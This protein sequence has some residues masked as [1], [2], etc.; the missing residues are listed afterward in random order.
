MS[1]VKDSLNSLDS[2][3]GMFFK[4]RR[5]IEDDGHF[6]R[7]EDGTV[8]ARMVGKDSLVGMF[9]KGRRII[10]DDGHFIRVE[11]GT[12]YARMVGGGFC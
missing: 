4:G 8:Y 9:F 2:L 3:V 12:V 10:E 5:I 1:K 11:D 7:V 6:I